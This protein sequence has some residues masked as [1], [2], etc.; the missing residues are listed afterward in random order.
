MDDKNLTGCRFVWPVIYSGE[1][2]NVLVVYDSHTS[3]G[4]TMSVRIVKGAMSVCV[5]CAYG[6]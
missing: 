6:V 2:V 3:R 4:R 1:T 5:R